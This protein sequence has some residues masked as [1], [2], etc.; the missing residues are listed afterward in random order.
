MTAT[1]LMNLD[2][3][4]FAAR[5]EGSALAVVPFLSMLHLQMYIRFFEPAACSTGSRI[6]NQ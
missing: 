3:L 2:F 5:E 4:Y 6:G 1:N